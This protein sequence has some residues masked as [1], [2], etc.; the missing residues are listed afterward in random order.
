M[1]NLIPIVL[2]ISF[3]GMFFFKGYVRLYLLG[4]QSSYCY[5]HRRVKYE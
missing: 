5:V 4:E 2:F 1:K 3:L